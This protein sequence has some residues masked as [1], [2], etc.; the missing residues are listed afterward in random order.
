MKPW[1][2]RSCGRNCDVGRAERGIGVAGRRS[3]AA[4]VQAGQQQ[5]V[6]RLRA[7]RVRHGP[8]VDNGEGDDIIVSAWV[9]DEE[10]A[11]ARAHGFEIVGVV[12]SK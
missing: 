8:R 11:L 10:L 5:P 3:G 9:N 12:H 4:A 7:A 6:R 1:Y 2:C